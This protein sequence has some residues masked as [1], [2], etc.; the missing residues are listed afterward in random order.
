MQNT[1]ENWDEQTLP[2]PNSH[3][4]LQPPVDDIRLRQIHEIHE[5]TKSHGLPL[6]IWGNSN[7]S[8]CIARYLREFGIV[9]EIRNVVDDEYFYFESE[10]LGQVIP[11]SVFLQKYAKNSVMVFGFYHYERILEAKKKYASM[12]PHLFDFHI[13]TVGGQRVK[14]EKSYFMA[15]IRDYTAT[16]KML[17]DDKSRE[18][19]V[20]WMAA[21]VGGEFDNLYRNCHEDEVYFNSLTHSL[22]PVTLVDCGAFDGDSIHDFVSY[23]PNYRK[24]YAFE[25]DHGNVLKILNRQRQESIRDLD[26]LE[27]GVYSRTGE[28]R[29]SSGNETASYVATSGAVINAVRLDD[30]SMTSAE[31]GKM[32]IKMDIEGSE[33]EALRGAEVLIKKY[34]PCLAICVYHK[35]SDLIDIPRFIQG[36]VPTGTYNYYLRFH[37][38]DLAEL[39]FYAIPVGWSKSFGF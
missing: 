37:G 24:V 34:N 11:L 14:W 21:A 2:H 39:V 28:L 33:S 23:F 22:E 12:I 35:E 13:T 20:H 3:W 31:K 5:L 32:F 38:Y 4:A 30:C 15:N 36:I 8:R 9:E 16:L 7:T 17:S 26:V 25:P 19:L 18:T 1:N 6:F 29:F 27:R 10:E